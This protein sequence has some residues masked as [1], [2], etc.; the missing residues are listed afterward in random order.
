M[1]K[2]KL[3]LKNIRLDKLLIILAAGIVIIV[4]SLPGQ[5]SGKDVMPETTASVSGYDQNT[6]YEKQMEA[7]LKKALSYV[8]GVGQVEVM[9]TL[10][11]TEESVVQTD[12]SVTSNHTSETDSQGGTRNVDEYSEDSDSLVTDNGSGS[13][14]YVIKQIMPEVEGVII[15]ADGGDKPTVKNEIYEAVQALFPVPTHKIKVLKRASTDS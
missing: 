3:N 1:E 6:S 14:P 10:K 11:S 13:S 15:V 9:I 8:D 4:L 5:N 7:R 12:K 2:K